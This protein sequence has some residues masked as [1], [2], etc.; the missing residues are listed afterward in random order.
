MNCSNCGVRTNKLIPVHGDIVQGYFCEEC[1]KAFT[2]YEEI[3]NL[4]YEN[5]HEKN[6]WQL[7]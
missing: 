2:T 5:N 4:F 3:G 6:G 1:V 7:D